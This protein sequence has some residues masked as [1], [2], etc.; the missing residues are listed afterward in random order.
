MSNTKIVV[1]KRKQ[2]L[3]AGIAIAAGILLVLCLILSDSKSDKTSPTKPST[4]APENEA[5]YNAGIYT[6]VISL[7]DTLLNLEVIVDT[8]HI[9]SVRIVNLDESV[10]TMYPLVG[11]ALDSI[12][13]QLNAGTALSAITLSEESKYTQTLLISAIEKTLA[14]AAIE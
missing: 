4:T 7:N 1:L 14:K 5:C 12:V 11:P 2:L 3:Y 6:S 10:A 8:N 9:N 13:G